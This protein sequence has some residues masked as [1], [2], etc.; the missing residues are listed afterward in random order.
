MLTIISPQKYLHQAGLT[1]IERQVLN[2]K[3]IATAESFSL[4]KRQNEWLTTRVCAKM[5]ALQYHAT[6]TG[7]PISLSPREIYISNNQTGRPELDGTL[8]QELQSTDLSISHGAGFGLALIADSRCGID[9]QEPRDS[10]IR[11]RD[12]FC[13]PEEEELLH[14]TLGELPE[15]HYLTLLWTAKEAGKKALS[16]MRMPGFGELI[17]TDLEP[18]TGGWAIHFLVSTRQFQGYP[19]T[20]TVA[21]EL[22]DGYSISICLSGE[23][24]N[25]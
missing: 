25:A 23:L 7:S 24:I 18:H 12:K 21:A 17:L 11:V 10:I 6:I 2:D 15:R 16:H 14:H 22:Y 5:A 3:E 9:I 19:A 4:E 13:T 8:T 20:L 1:P